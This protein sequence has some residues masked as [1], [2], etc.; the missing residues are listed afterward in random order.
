MPALDAIGDGAWILFLLNFV[1]EGSYRVPVELREE[2]TDGG[3]EVGIH[4]LKHDGHLFASHRGFKRR[5]ER[6]NGYARKWGASGFRSGFMLRNLDW[7]HDLDVQY[8]ASTSIRT[9]SSHSQTGVTP[10]SRFGCLAQTAIQLTATNPPVLLLRELVTLSSLIHCHRTQRS[11][12][13][14]VKAPQ[15]SGCAS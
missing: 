6:I 12:W 2:L 7:L 13:C 11:S 3:F 15:R 4:D 14:C 5:A 8:D 1:P 10:S 9:H